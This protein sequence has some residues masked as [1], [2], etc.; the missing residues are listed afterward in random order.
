[1]LLETENC[2]TQRKG[3]IALL[4]KMGERADFDYWRPISLFNYNYRICTMAEFKSF[5]IRDLP[6]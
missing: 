1:M 5:A 4:Y 3:V 2:H 6:N